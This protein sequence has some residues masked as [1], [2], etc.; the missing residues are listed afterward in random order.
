MASTYKNISFEIRDKIGIIKLNRPKLLNSWDDAVVADM[1]GAFRELDEHPH[2]VFTVLTGEGR[3]FSAGADVR[4]GIPSLPAE[5]TAAE[6]KLFFMNK[7]STSVELFRSM[8]DHKKVFVLAMNGPAVGGG[9]AWFNGIADIVL[10]ASNTYIQVPFSSLGLVPEYGSANIF[11]QSMGVR[12][13]NDLLMFGR[14]CPVE[15]LQACGL[16]NRVFPVDGFQEHVRKFLEEQLAANDGKSMMEVKRLQNAPL[17]S[18]RL[19]AVYEATHALAERFV[20]GTPYE[21]FR[22][23]REQ[24]IAASKKREGKPK[25]SL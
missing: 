7:F 18:D 9:A 15:E 3:F 17:R 10:A 22:A 16:V 25:A 5:A 14:K 11:A 23:R 24:L 20:D 21:R 12:R 4:A 19:L 1:V 2:T 13:A 8:I 6:K